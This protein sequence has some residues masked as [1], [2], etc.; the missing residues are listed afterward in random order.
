MDRQGRAAAC[1]MGIWIVPGTEN[2]ALSIT[3]VDKRR[4]PSFVVPNVGTQTIEVNLNMAYT[5]RWLL[6]GVSMCQLQGP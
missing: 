5:A 2:P 1:M 3:T 4:Q 6:T